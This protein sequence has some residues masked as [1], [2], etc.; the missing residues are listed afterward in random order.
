MTYQNIGAGVSLKI[1]FIHFRVV[2]FKETKPWGI[3]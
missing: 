1:H 2:F 3:E